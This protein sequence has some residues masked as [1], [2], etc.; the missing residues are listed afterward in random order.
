MSSLYS[1]ES[2]RCLSLY[3]ENAY[4]S[5]LLSRLLPLLRHYAF[6]L[7]PSLSPLQIFSSDLLNS[8]S[9]SGLARSRFLRV[10]PIHHT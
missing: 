10:L 5:F 9:L 4:P 2:P 7:L 8:L 3:G 1:G 6:Y